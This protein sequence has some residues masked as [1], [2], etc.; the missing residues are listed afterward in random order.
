MTPNS[1]ILH[2]HDDTQALGRKLAQQLT[3]RG[4]L[5]LLEGDLGAGKT[6]F[7]Q[8]FIRELRPGE[9]SILSPTFSVMNV[10]PGEPVIYHFDLYRLAS[11]DEIEQ[12]GLWEFLNDEYAIRLVEWPQIAKPGLSRP[13]IRV[14]LS[15]NSAHAKEAVITTEV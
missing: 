11:V 9:T 6:T 8:G 15:E 1:I 10:Y 7:A 2:T 3:G 14:K 12:L 13:Y 4:Q 5:I